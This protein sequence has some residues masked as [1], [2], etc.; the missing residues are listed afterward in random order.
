MNGYGHFLPRRALLPGVL[1]RGRA[2]AAGRSRYLFWARHGER[3][4]RAA[5]GGDGAPDAAPR[6][7]S[8]ASARWRSSA[9][10]GFIFYNTNVLN[11]YARRLRPAGAAGRLREAVQAARRP[12]RSRRS[13]AVT[14]AVDLFPHEQRVRMRGT[15]RAREQAGA[16]GRRRPPAGVLRRPTARRARA[17]RSA[18]RRR[19]TKDD[20]DARRAQLPARDAA[21]AGR[22]DDARL[23]PR[24][25]DARLHATTA[26]TPPSSTTARSST[27]ATCCRS[28]ATRSAA[29]SRR[30][31]DRK[32]F[33]L[34]PK[35]RMRDRDDP[36]GLARERAARATPTSSRSR[37][38]SAPSADQIAIAPGYLQREWTEDGRRYFHY[39]M[40]APILNFFA[41][42]SARYAVK[43]D[44]W[45]DTTS[46]SRSTTSPATSTTSTAMIAASKDVARLLHAALRPLPAPAVPHHRVPALRDASRSRSPTRSRTRRRSASSPACATTT[47]RTSTTRTT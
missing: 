10:G 4:A 28:S 47:R 3:L 33:G 5:G 38:R 7:A 26:R 31:R 36:A 6:S 21:A 40:D 12:S 13:T 25:A 15:L 24:A 14:L 16:A 45:L 22:D 46:R 44:V 43:K 20:V 23:R 35:E 37:R 41:F 19:S 2:A 8:P 32:K 30:D 29:S 9:L 1:G 18:C 42:Q 34:A 11:R 27:A 17:R 39:K